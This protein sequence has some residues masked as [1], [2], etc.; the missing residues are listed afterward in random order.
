MSEPH[1]TAPTAAGD[2]GA[3]GDPSTGSDQPELKKAITPK[4]LLLFIVGD[5]L[6]TGVYSLTGKVAGEVGGAGWLPIL[7]A[8]AVAM[9]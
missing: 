2:P 6:G 7:I 9:V 5:I 1:E 3:A 4:L 8:F